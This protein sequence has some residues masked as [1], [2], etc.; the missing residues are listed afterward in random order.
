MSALASK[1]VANE[2]WAERGKAVSAPNMTMAAGP[3]KTL[4]FMFTTHL[5][6]Q[7][8]ADLEETAD[9]HDL[10]DAERPVGRA[11]REDRIRIQ[12]VVEIKIHGRAALPEPQDLA[13]AQVKLIHAVS[14]QCA[15]G[16][17]CWR[18]RQRIRPEEI[19]LR[20]RRVP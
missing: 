17:R 5:E 12:R 16:G 20:V 18:R 14:V 2:W 4:H 19:H 1:A 7:L 13:D 15:G 8:R 10:R 3:A 6:I 9:H 11:F